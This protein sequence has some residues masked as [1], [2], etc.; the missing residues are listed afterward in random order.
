MEAFQGAGDVA[1][2]DVPP[3]DVEHDDCRVSVFRQ[4]IG[5]GQA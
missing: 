5:I 2:L 4:A 3:P 1:G